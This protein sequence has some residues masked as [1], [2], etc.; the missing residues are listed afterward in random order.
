MF[1]YIKENGNELGNEKNA[2]KCHKIFNCKNVTLNASK[3]S[4]ITIDI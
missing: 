1:P 2:K 4:P 3:L